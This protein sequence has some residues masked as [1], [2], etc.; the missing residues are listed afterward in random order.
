MIGKAEERESRKS[1]L[2]VWLHDDDDINEYFLN[3]K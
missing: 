3:I 2:S 1:M